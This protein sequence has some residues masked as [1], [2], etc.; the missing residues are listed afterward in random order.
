M[1]ENIGVLKKPDKIN[2]ISDHIIRQIRDCIA[3]G[4]FKP[5]DK[6]GSE[7]ELI[8]QLGVSKASMREALRVLEIMGI[9]V[10]RKG[11]SGGVFVADIVMKTTLLSIMN[12]IKF[13]A[14]SIRDITQMRYVLEPFIL[15]S[16]FP[17][18]T[19]ADLEKLRESNEMEFQRVT[20]ETS[21]KGISFHRYLVRVTQNPILIIIMDFIDN[22]TAD[23][24]IKANVGDEF[25]SQV[26]E[27]HNQVI[28]RL[29]VK[30]L[31]GAIEALTA[32]IIFVGDYMASKLNSLRF[33]PTAIQCHPEG[34]SGSYKA[35]NIDGN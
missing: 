22:L 33:D 7:K 25:Y 17:L 34:Y 28:N 31:F 21:P 30:D 27:L 18:I 15:R 2:K 14:V 20:E 9:I 5:G 26:K 29:M 35:K 19:V 6:I 12:F 8:S 23:M 32:D 16:I 4:I 10:I 3:S 24:K 11:I 13:E 1:I